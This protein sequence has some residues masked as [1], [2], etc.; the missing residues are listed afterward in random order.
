M[1]IYDPRSMTWDQWCKLTCERFAALALQPAPETQW[2]T[3]VANLLNF[4]QFPSEGVP[5]ARGFKTWRDWA[6]QFNGI[7]G[8]R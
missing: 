4:G 7:V 5:D 8:A 6:Y 1:V 2:R 3:W